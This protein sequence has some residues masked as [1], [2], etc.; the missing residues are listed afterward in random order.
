MCHCSRANE[1]ADLDHIRQHA[2][3]SATEI[4]NPAI[5]QQVA[6][7]AADS[8]TIRSTFT[9]LL[10]I[11]FAG[12]VVNSGCSFAIGNTLQYWRYRLP[13]VH[14]ATGKVPRRLGA[15]SWKNHLPENR[16]EF[17][18]RTV[19]DMRIQTAAT[20]LVSSGFG[21]KSSAVT[22]QHGACQHYR[23]TRATAFAVGRFHCTRVIQHPI[24][25]LE[26]TGIAVAVSLSSHSFR[27]V[28]L[29]AGLHQDIRIL[30][31]V[32][33]QGLILLWH[34]DDL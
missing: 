21:N 13:K 2:V 28:I 9:Q 32:T 3:F 20:D 29:S 5:G 30:L 12:C 25:C 23:T 15:S 18:P 4:I 33:F 6:A 1:R 11:R 10:N 27:P 16:S 19:G 22:R 14:P 7:N 8:G 17:N 26:D 24:V 34:F 31:M